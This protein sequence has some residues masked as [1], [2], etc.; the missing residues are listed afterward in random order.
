MYFIINKQD[1]PKK[2]S[3]SSLWTLLQWNENCMKQRSRLFYNLLWYLNHWGLP[4]WFSTVHTY[5]S[6][7]FSIHVFQTQ[8]KVHREN[9]GCTDM[10]AALREKVPNVLS[11]CMTLYVIWYPRQKSSVVYTLDLHW[12]YTLCMLHYS[13]CTVYT[14]VYAPTQNPSLATLGLHGLHYSVCTVYTASVRPVYTLTT[15]EFGLGS[16]DSS[17]IVS[18]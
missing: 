8:C 2:G 3:I 4:G 1:V 12:H 10:W 17:S 15:L 16:W 18:N 13:V 7:K 5:A 9:H 11:H 14:A 6:N